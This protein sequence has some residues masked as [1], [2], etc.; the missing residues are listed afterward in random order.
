MLYRYSKDGRGRPVKTAAIYT[1]KEHKISLDKID[2]DCLRVVLTNEPQY[3]EKYRGIVSEV[4]G[5]RVSNGQ[6]DDVCE[7][8][9]QKQ[10]NSHST[11]Q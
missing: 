8:R 6:Y 10:R 9:T 4:H 2:A 3:I 11:V 1:K 5:G 7:Q